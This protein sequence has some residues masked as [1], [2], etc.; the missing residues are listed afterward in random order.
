MRMIILN[1]RIYANRIRLTRLLYRVG[2][3][4]SWHS[5]ARRSLDSRPPSDGSGTSYV[6][7]DYLAKISLQWKLTVSVGTSVVWP[8]GIGG[9]GNDGVAEFQLVCKSGGSD[10]PGQK[11]GPD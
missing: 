9:K 2:G 1:L 11:A 3:G 4:K 8:V 10:K 7:A 6:W 5:S